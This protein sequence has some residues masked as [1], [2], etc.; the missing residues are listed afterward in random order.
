MAQDEPL[1]L[2]ALSL[3]GEHIHD[4]YEFLAPCDPEVPLRFELGARVACRVT[5]A[6]SWHRAN[7]VTAKAARCGT[8]LNT[9]GRREASNHMK[10]EGP[11][12]DERAGPRS[13][14]ARTPRIGSRG[15]GS[16]NQSATR[17]AAACTP[18]T[19]R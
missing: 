9:G 16:V 11:V 18:R 6:R 5:H 10:G 3:G 15:D 1:T 17:R 12:K 14:V 4:D 7:W 2:D 13:D 8:S 19:S